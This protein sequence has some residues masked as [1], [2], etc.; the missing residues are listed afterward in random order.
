MAIVTCK[1]CKKKFDREAVPSI[2]IQVGEK[3]FR[4][5]HPECYEEA[6][7]AKK[8]P[9]EGVYLDPGEQIV[10]AICGK[11]M[12]RD[13]EDC[14]QLGVNRY[15]H[16]E[17]VKKDQ[18]VEKTPKDK[19][20]DFIMNQTRY[21]YVTPSMQ[22]QI[23]QMIKTYNF[24]YSG[25]HG[26]LRYWYIIK[27]KSLD[28]EN[29]LAIVPYKYDEAKK[30]YK[31]VYEQRQKNAESLNNYTEKVEVIRIAKPVLRGMKKT[32]FSFL[33]EEEDGNVNGE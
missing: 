22:K 19:L 30:F 15:A 9:R 5:A 33:D 7:T 25:I 13:A 16:K 20:F 3:T 26:C 14:I 28:K 31:E 6:K 12:R 27:G 10:C 1:Y 32:E 8:E 17:C 4:Y 11:A 18:L 29:F 21:E 23:E 2:Q 24:T